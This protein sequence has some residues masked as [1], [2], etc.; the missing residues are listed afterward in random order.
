VRRGERAAGINW[1]TRQETEGRQDMGIH[2]GMGHLKREVGSHGSCAQ[3]G[4]EVPLSP[5]SIGGIVGTRL[6][7]WQ[8]VQQKCTD[9]IWRPG[10]GDGRRDLPGQS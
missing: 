4:W 3:S 1:H 8:Q 7:G 9:V 2:E 10:A 6:R 5:Y